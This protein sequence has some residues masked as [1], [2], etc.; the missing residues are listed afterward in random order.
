MLLVSKTNVVLYQIDMQSPTDVVI[1]TICGLALNSSIS[2]EGILKD[3]KPLF[4]VFFT[5]ATV[6]TIDEE[7]D[8]VND[9]T[10]STKERAD[11]TLTKFEKTE[12]NILQ[13]QQ[14]LGIGLT[15]TIVNSQ[16][17]SAKKNGTG[18]K[19]TT[20]MVYLGDSKAYLHVY[21]ITNI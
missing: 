7:D 8:L 1:E 3:N 21:K 18:K 13:S 14:T 4:D 17:C 12:G 2:R 16:P 20:L 9:F 19:K 6:L 10:T 15:N 5:C 11:L